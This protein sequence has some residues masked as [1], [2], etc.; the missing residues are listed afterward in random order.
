MAHECHYALPDNV[1]EK[2]R[3][4]THVVANISRR[5][6]YDAIQKF[7]R[8]EVLEVVANPETIRKRLLARGRESEPEIMVRLLREVETNWSSG[9]P[10]T[11]ISNDGPLG[12]AVDKFIAAVLSRSDQN[13]QQAQMA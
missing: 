6:V 10:V 9:A 11:T 13:V 4:D 12:E 8:V 3:F 2:L 1:Y 7:N 5:A